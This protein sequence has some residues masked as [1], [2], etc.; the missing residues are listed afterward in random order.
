MNSYWGGAVAATGG[1]LVMGAFPRIYE[2]R[3]PRDA[4]AFGLGRGKFS[5][6]AGSLKDS[7][8]AFR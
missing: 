1:A 2:R 3:R 5:Q 7:F 8:S 6:Q 4:V